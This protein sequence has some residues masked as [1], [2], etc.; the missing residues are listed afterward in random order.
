VSKKGEGTKIK[1]EKQRRR[2]LAETKKRD[3][4]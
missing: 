3:Q 1:G 2:F 4:E